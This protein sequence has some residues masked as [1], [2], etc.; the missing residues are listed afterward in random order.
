MPELAISTDKVAFLIEKAREFDVKEGES[1][2]DSGSNGA[3]DDMVDV[4]EDTGDDPVVQE[5]SGFIAAMTEEEQIDLVALM[6]LGRGDGSI[7]EW[8]DLRREAAEGRNG[9]TA[10]YLLG[11]PLLGDYLADGLDQFGLSWSDERTTPVV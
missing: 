3:D 7:E 9:R 4:L 5:I 8:E 2:A 11:E 10:R 1:D 6:R